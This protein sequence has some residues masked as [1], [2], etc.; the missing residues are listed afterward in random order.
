[1][2]ENLEAWLTLGLHSAL[3]GKLGSDWCDRAPATDID[4]HALLRTLRRQPENL[5][6]YLA[7]AM[8]WQGDDRHLL[9]WNS[10]HYP[11]LLREI[12]DPPP[13]LYVQGSLD[14]LSGPKLAIVGSRTP[15]P[16][17]RENATAFAQTLAEMGLAVV[18][19]LALGVDAAAHQGALNGKGITI[20]V[21]G[22]GVDRVYPAQHRKL[23]HQIVDAGGCLISEYPLGAPPLK[24]QFPRRNR[25]ISGLSVGTL[26]VEAALS[27]GSLI[28]A[29][30]ALEQGREVFAI[31]GSIHNPLAKGCHQLIR[32]G[33]KLVETAQHVL[34]ELSVILGAQLQ[35][36]ETQAPVQHAAID[37][38]L[39]SEMGWDPVDT[40]TLIERLQWPAEKVVEQLLALELDG[41]VQAVPGGYQRKR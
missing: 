30:Q 8:A 29:R 41:I 16:N 12:A 20:A 7:L 17:G 5:E 13:L 21:A 18:S 35:L 4:P 10:P 9:S 11:A 14:A 39:L 32:Q 33:A 19:G 24:H 38:P 22:T 2:S 25:I 1:M 28:T 31:P 3:G 26:V 34:E 23:A 37:N 27:S 36:L 15:T 40:D 6:A